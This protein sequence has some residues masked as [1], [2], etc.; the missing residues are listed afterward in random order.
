MSNSLIIFFVTKLFI[1]LKIRNYLNVCPK[2]KYFFRIQESIIERCTANPANLCNHQ[3]RFM[4]QLTRM[5]K[6]TKQILDTTI[7]ME[8]QIKILKGSRWYFKT[9]F[10]YSKSCFL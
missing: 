10:S 6:Q 5:E 9:K 8:Q 7:S 2:Q 1:V 3:Q 4:D